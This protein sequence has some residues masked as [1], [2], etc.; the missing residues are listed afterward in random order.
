MSDSRDLQPGQTVEIQ[1]LFRA[2]K[3]PYEM[4]KLRFKFMHIPQDLPVELTKLVCFPVFYHSFFRFLKLSHSNE[5]R[6]N[7]DMKGLCCRRRISNIF[8]GKFELVKDEF[9][10]SMLLPGVIFLEKKEYKS[11]VLVSGVSNMHTLNLY[12]YGAILR[13][14]NDEHILLRLSIDNTNAMFLECLTDSKTPSGLE[15]VDFLVNHLVYVLSEDTDT[16]PSFRT[17]PTKAS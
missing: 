13:E 11:T 2:I 14:T 16:Q 6:Y 4:P 12:Q 1:T 3:V 7:W 9:H 5:F 17:P 8:I 15:R 10:L